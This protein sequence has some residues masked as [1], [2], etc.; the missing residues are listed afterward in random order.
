MGKPDGNCRGG[1]CHSE[2][3]SGPEFSFEELTCQ[4]LRQVAHL[5]CEFPGLLGC[6][7][8]ETCTTTF[9]IE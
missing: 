4:W 8:G 9:C 1:V 3:F 2:G 6:P 7:S 5:A